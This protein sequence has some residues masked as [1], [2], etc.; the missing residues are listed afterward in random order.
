MAASKKAPMEPTRGGLSGETRKIT[1]FYDGNKYKD[2]VFVGINGMT[3]LVKRGEEVEVPV[4]VYQVL[5]QQM[6]Q[7][8]KTAQMISQFS[9]E[10]AEVLAEA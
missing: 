6:E 7:D 4:E 2:P 9:K 10:A 8:N 1:L 3:W 5:V